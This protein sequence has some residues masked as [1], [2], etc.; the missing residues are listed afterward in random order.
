MFSMLSAVS[1]YAAYNGE[2]V[3]LPLLT[4][5]RLVTLPRTSSMTMQRLLI[6]Q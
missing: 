2:V 4:M 3:R 1:H 5:Q 6:S